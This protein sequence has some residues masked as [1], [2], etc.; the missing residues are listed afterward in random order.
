MDTDHSDVVVI[1]G[2]ISGLT[3]AWCLKKAGVNVCLLEA[4]STVG[5]CLLINSI[6][7]CVALRLTEAGMPPTVLSAPAVVGEEESVR[8][9]ERA[10]DEHARRLAKLYAGLGEEAGDMDE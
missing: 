10:Y 1:G 8:L 7:A 3:A 6:K 2:G 5:G 4:G 9:F